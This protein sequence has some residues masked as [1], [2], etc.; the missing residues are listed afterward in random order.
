[1]ELNSSQEI[2]DSIESQ[3]GVI[4]TILMLTGSGVTI[5]TTLKDT[6]AAKYSSIV[7]DF[8]KRSK[9]TVNSI[10]PDDKI[11][12]LRI[13]SFKNEILIFP[14]KVFTLIAIQDAMVA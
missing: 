14:D 6:E 5:K 8:I 12:C 11:Q 4:G 13:R 1:M 7:S 10:S 2:L 3:P 9:A